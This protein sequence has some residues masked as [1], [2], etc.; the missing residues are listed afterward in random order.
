VKLARRLPPPRSRPAKTTTAKTT[1]TQ[2][3][4]VQPDRK[5]GEVRDA[6]LAML[7]SKVGPIAESVGISAAH[8]S[9]TLTRL[10][11]QGLAERGADG[12]WSTPTKRRGR[13]AKAD[14]AS[15]DE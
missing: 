11:K 12:T 8:A 5:R 6:V 9:A 1:K 15:E 14:D 7:P 2:A 13:K 3:P 4:E 10:R